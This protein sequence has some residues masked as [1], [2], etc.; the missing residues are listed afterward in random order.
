MS[1]KQIKEINNLIF[2]M[3][4]QLDNDYYKLLRESLEKETGRLFPLNL[5]KPIN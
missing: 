5:G 2:H 3:F 4:Y 1:N